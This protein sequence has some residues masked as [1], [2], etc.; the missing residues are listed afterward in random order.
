MFYRKRPGKRAAVDLNTATAPDLKRLMA[1][2]AVWKDQKNKF[3]KTKK[4]TCRI[5]LSNTLLIFFLMTRSFRK[6]LRFFWVFFEQNEKHSRSRKN[7]KINLEKN[8]KLKSSQSICDLFITHRHKMHN[9]TQ[10]HLYITV[11]FLIH[12]SLKTEYFIYTY[13]NWNW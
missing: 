2:I 13:V 5:C 11:Y 9:H 3:Y 10:I 6:S 7:V 12:T 1:N 8:F 4:N